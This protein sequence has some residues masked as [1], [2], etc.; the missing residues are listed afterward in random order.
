MRICHEPGQVNRNI[1]EGSPLISIGRRRQKESVDPFRQAA[2]RS[3]VDCGCDFGSWLGR[4]AVV[5][6]DGHGAI[7]ADQSRGHRRRVRHDGCGVRIDSPGAQR[8]VSAYDLPNRLAAR[9]QGG[10]GSRTGWTDRRTRSAHLARLLR[11]CVQ[12][13][14]RMLCRA[15]KW[16]G[17]E[18]I[19][20]IGAT[21]S[22]PIRTSPSASR[23]LTATDG[24]IWRPIFPR[25]MV[26]PET[27]RPTDPLSLRN[28]VVRSAIL[29]RTLLV[30]IEM[31]SRRRGAGRSH[32]AR[33]ARFARG[34]R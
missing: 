29:L 3:D 13:P 21:R 32:P 18:R 6:E 11:E 33:G 34:D 14:A 31:I 28:Y 7:A 12:A 23:A 19:A 10:L 27:R 17:R 1:A 22:F 15:W 2:R 4:V 24:R 20:R 8:P 30:G 9:R 25:R 5:N 16:S 26:C